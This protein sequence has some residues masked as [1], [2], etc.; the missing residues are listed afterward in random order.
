MAGN[1][2]ANSHTK[3]MDI[4]Y[5]H[6]NKYVEDGRVKTVAKK[7]AENNTHRI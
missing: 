5:K 4:R 6:V 2:T 1:V 7:S 3:Y